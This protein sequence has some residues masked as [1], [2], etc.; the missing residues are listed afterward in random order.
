MD[1]VVLSM[2]GSRYFSGG[3]LMYYGISI[4]LKK[5]RYAVKTACRAFRVNRG[6][7]SRTR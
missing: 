5:A 6:F 3:F 2:V 4:N 7:D 1:E